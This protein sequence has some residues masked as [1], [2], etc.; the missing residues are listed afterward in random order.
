MNMSNDTIHYALD[1]NMTEADW[2]AW[3]KLAHAVN[4][5]NRGETS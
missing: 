5:A 2:E 1:P 4:E 3:K